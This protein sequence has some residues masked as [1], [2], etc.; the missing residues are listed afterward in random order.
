[1]LHH[2][3]ANHNHIRVRLYISKEKNV[4]FL[5]SKW[6]FFIYVLH[7][8]TITHCLLPISILSI[9]Y[10][11]EACIIKRKSLDH[12]CM[13]VGIESLHK[14]KS[15]RFFL[16][17]CCVCRVWEW[18]WDDRK[19]KERKKKANA[20]KYWKKIKKRTK[21]MDIHV[22]WDEMNKKERKKEKKKV[23]IN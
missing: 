11:I 12:S 15:L 17:V 13:C 2:C 21:Y 5:F 3:A 9:E 14:T 18:E 20:K 8:G 6:A 22:E 23:H 7:Y 4:T 19:K 1:M 10:I 16:F